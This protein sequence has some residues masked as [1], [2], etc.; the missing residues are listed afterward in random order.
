MRILAVAVQ[1]L[2]EIGLWA[3]ACQ[4]QAQWSPSLQSESWSGSLADAFAASHTDWVAIGPRSH[5][6]LAALTA[7]INRKPSEHPI[8][9]ASL[10][11][12][13]QMLVDGLVF[14]P[15]ALA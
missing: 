5:G 4:L 10:C 3:P 8:I 1:V 9:L 2:W 13:L 12:K 15:K 7:P 11:I 6:V 14:I